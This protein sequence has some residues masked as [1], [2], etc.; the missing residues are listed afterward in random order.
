MAT[1]EGS[2]QVPRFVCA[3]DLVPDPLLLFLAGVCNMGPWPVHGIQRLQSLVR[4]PTPP[5]VVPMH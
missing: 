3:P 4:H 2:F 5:T 1:A